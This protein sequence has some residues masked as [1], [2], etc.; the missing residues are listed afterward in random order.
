MN[1]HNPQEITVRKAH[2][3]K[4]GGGRNCDILGAHDERY[5]DEHF[6]CCTSWYLFQCR[7]CEHV[8]VQ[9]VY[10]DSENI[11]WQYGPNG[12]TEGYAVETM[13]Y[14]PALAKRRRPEWITAHGIDSDHN[15]RA[16]DDSLF[17][18]YGALDNDLTILAAI[19]IRTSFDIASELL[20][21]APEL[22]FQEKL[23]ELVNLGHIGTVDK[24][25]LDALI[26]AGSASAHRGW[27]PT[28]ED[29][30]TMMEVLENFLHASFVAPKKQK[31]LQDKVSKMRKTVPQ[32]SKK[33]GKIKAK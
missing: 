31:H 19:G 23:K 7:G 17:E 2:C 24:E 33:V 26:D 29:L 9:T 3:S 16:L 27:Q 15:V 30:N 21:I 6:D 8:F 18:L 11:D 5:N 12:E 20:G 1:T 28:T 22:R 25:H 10:T 4:C 32:R 14:W 13:R